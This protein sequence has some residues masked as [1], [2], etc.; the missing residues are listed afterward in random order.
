MHV[1]RF[2]AFFPDRVY[3]IDKIFPQ[4]Y[5]RKI[6]KLL[7]IEIIFK[8]S[9]NCIDH[10]MNPSYDLSSPRYIEI[11]LSKLLQKF[12]SPSFCH[13]LYLDRA[14]RKLHTHTHTHRGNK[15]KEK[16]KK[17]EA[18]IEDITRFSNGIIKSDF[19]D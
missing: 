4:Q 1:S 7:V 14:R 12:T 18:K 19:I 5:G 17:R 11:H 6:E 3:P 16:A 10:L 15:D 9:E 13:K 2:S 8:E